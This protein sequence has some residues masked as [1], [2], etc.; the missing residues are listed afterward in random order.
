MDNDKTYI[1]RKR[2]VFI[3]KISSGHKISKDGMLRRFGLPLYFNMEFLRKN[4]FVVEMQVDD[5]IINSDN[6]QG[7]S[8][9]HLHDNEKTIKVNTVINIDDWIQNYEQVNIIKIYLL[10]GLGNV[11]R[12]FDLDVV[13]KGYTFDCDYKDDSPILPYFTYKIIE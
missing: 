4:R 10:D 6:I 2:T 8:I 7:F 3:E 13:Y 9:T 12:E 1:G 11:H 5:D